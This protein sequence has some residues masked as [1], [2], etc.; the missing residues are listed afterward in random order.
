LGERAPQL[1][2]VTGETREALR[3]NANALLSMD[4]LLEAFAG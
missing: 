3:G 4:L 2:E 1:A